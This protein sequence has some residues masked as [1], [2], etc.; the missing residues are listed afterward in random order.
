MTVD[1][2]LPKPFESPPIN[3]QSLELRRMIREIL[4]RALMAALF[5]RGQ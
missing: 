1:N 4:R 2:D 5:R 3:L